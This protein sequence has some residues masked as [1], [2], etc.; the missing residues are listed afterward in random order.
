MLVRMQTYTATHHSKGHDPSVHGNTQWE[1][2]SQS[3]LVLN[4]PRS[5]GTFN[6]HI[7]IEES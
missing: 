7:A 3:S 4:S 2:M 6:T 1:Q 5:N